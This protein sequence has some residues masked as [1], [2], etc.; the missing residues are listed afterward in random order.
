MAS[1][2]VY[3]ERSDRGSCLTGARMVTLRADEHWAAPEGDAGREEAVIDRAAEWIVSKVGNSRRLAMLVLDADGSVCSWATV[4]T[5]DPAVVDAVVR[6]QS[7]GADDARS[8]EQETEASSGARAGVI[9]YYAAEATDSTIQPLA[10]SRIHAGGED[11]RQ[12]AAVLAVG[13][14]IARVLVDAIDRLG[15]ECESAYSIWHALAAAWDPAGRP[16]SP[17]PDGDRIVAESR[18]TSPLAVVVVEPRG[19]VLWAWSQAGRLLVG[20]SARLPVRRASQAAEGEVD[21]PLLTRDAAA[22]LTADWLAW[23]A[24]LALAPDRIVMLIPALAE[25][26]RD[27]SLGAGGFGRAIAQSWSGA[28][29]DVVVHD[30]PIGATLRRLAEVVDEREGAAPTSESSDPARTLVTLTNRPGGAHRKLYLWTSLAVTACAVVVGAVAWGLRVKAS[31]L[32]ALTRQVEGSWRDSFK[33]V[34]LARP[35]MPGMEVMDLAS[36]VERVRRESAPISGVE[37]AKPIVREFET[38]SLVL[39]LPDF[40][41]TSILLD[42]QQGRVTIQVN[43]PDL[44]GAEAL[45]DALGRIAGSEIPAWT[46]TPGT[47]LQGTDKVPCTYTGAFGA[48]NAPAPAPR[49]SGGGA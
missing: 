4:P 9:G 10:S 28:P 17:V 38:L 33:E 15:V 8:A 30:D 48:A 14:G 13:D 3:I 20:G 24:Q 36:E 26:P 12:R 16:A 46:F 2:I 39:A 32:S 1:R 49:P 18:G 35:P 37:P 29:V 11:A 25:E 21:I 5:T 40:E 43:A 19:R 23:A 7:D 31:R 42:T 47:R 44:A 27:D 41:L 45:S 34:K 22:R 6:Q